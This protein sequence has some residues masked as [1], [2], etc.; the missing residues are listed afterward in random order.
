[1]TRYLRPS[2]ILLILL[3]PNLSMAAESLPEIVK[4]TKPAIVEIVAMDEKG[5]PTKLGTGFLS[6]QTVWLSPTSM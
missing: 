2:L 1:M 6:L 4:K 5:S 3:V